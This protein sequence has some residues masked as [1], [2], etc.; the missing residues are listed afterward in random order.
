MSGQAKY[1]INFWIELG[2]NNAYLW[3]GNEE[4]RRHFGYLVHPTD[5][6]SE[7]LQTQGREL[8]DWFQSSMNWENP[9]APSPWKQEECDRFRE[10][11]RAFFVD[12]QQELGDEFDLVYRQTEPDEDPNLAAFEATQR[13]V[14]R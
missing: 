14:L 3:P 8:S 9:L 12:V 6:L 5:I 4:T 7:A 2:S 10:A 1:S 11:I 13:N